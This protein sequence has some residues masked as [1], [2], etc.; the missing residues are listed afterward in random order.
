M[1]FLFFRFHCYLRLDTPGVSGA[2]LLL[3]MGNYAAVLGAIDDQEF[4]ELFVLSIG[5]ILGLALFSTFLK[6]LLDKH[7]D[8]VLSCL[9]GL[10]LGSSRVLWPWPN[11]VGVIND[12]GNEL[13]SGTT[14][15]WPR[16]E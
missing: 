2:F 12:D 14:L 5:A 9:I 10:M 11:G 15:D 16:F 4:A 6:T 1:D 7:R 8:F 3:I 13:V